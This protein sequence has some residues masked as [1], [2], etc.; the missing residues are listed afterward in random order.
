MTQPILPPLEQVPSPNASSRNGAPIERVIAHD[1]E[2]SY[3]GAV[4]WFKEPRSQVSAHIVL[5]EDGTEATQC[6]PFEL[7]AWH[8]C[9]QN[10]RT[11]GVEI[12]GR[13]AHGFSADELGADAIVIAWLLRTY[14]LPCRWAE[15]GE[16]LGF[17]S[18]WDC[19]PSGGGHS[20]ITT[21][22]AVWAAFQARVEAAYAAWGDGP[23][24]AWGLHGAPAPHAV[25]PAPIAPAGWSPSGTTR[26]EPADVAIAP[27]P[28]A[29]G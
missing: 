26:K 11:I 25:S 7:K 24:P 27:M 29:G 8:A 17:C 12:A 14:G 3:A 16:G 6:V 5:N 18:H 13:S 9:Q 19:G 2:G 21:D 4:S 15:H 22:P 1:C 10:S 23:Y 20:D 28:G